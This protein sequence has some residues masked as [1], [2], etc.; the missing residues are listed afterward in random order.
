MILVDREID[1]APRKLLLHAP[2]N[3]LFY[4]LDRGTGKLV[5]AAKFVNANW[6]TGVDAA[7]GRPTIDRSAADYRDHA[8][9]VFPSVVG[10]HSWQPMAFSPQTG[11]VYLPT[12]NVGTLLYDES[13]QIGY[14]PTLFNANVGLVFSGFIDFLKDS[15]PPAVKQD[16]PGT[17]PTDP[18]QL[19]MSAYLQA[20]D[21]VAQR[22]VW[23]T[24]A[25]DWWDHAGVLASAGGLVFQG[26]DRGVLRVFD[27][28][29]G[30]LLRSIDTGTPIIAAP[31]MYRVAGVSYVTVL[32][33]WGG[34]GWAVPHPDSAAYQRG[35]AGRILA[36][37]LGG[38]AVP[39]PPLL[40]PDPPLPRPPTQ[41]V[42]A[43]IL[44]K[45][46]SLF[47]SNCAICHPN[48]PRSGSADL[49]RMSP[50]I[51]AV[52]NQI[53]LQ[54][55]KRD[56]GMP[57]W[58]DV[59]SKDDADAIHAFLIDQSTQAYAAQEKG[60]GGNAGTGIIKGY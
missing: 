22:A 49:R 13:A 26:S 7:S 57:A 50:G 48:Q 20:W 11:L 43:A 24:A 60:T 55:L 59:L 53:V 3:G 9:L 44:A 1:G 19:R 25:G 37:K 23:R 40:P 45:G 6:T 31:A 35:N 12:T 15:L 10:A 18:A 33:G 38:T 29:S 46:G 14:R 42:T 17:L 27:A 32:A 51:H 36:F 47:G 4:V 5:S 16:L 54:G 8:K 2:K 28:A 39:L 21:P 58:G 56:A 30:A 41:H 52:F 34:G